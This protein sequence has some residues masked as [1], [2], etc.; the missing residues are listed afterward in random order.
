M[1][2]HGYAGPRHERLHGARHAKPMP[3]SALQRTAAAGGVAASLIVGESLALG[4][5]ANA[6]TPS[7]WAQLRACESSGNYAVNTGNGYYGAYQFDA[8]TWHGL[9]YQ[10]LASNAPPAVQDQAAQRLYQSRGWQPWP[11]CSAKLGLIDDRAADRGAARLPL[12]PVV[13]TIASPPVVAAPRVAPAPVVAPAPAVAPAMAVATVQVVVPVVAL[14][15]VVAPAPAAPA[16]PP[17]AHATAPVTASEGWRGHY[18]TTADVSEVRTDVN[19]W[20]TAMVAAGYPIAIDG[21]YGPQSAAAT[22][23]F[24]AAH[25]LVVE[26]PG[27]VGPQVWSALA[28]LSK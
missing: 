20:Q 19:G 2:S 17:A 6:L 4:G 18:F 3:P 23:R 9:G 13:A 8:Q 27:I 25:G 21:R 28:A 14:T 1:G 11:A 22:T 12:A 24:E 26:N 7:T 10:G 16:A 15:P 5:V